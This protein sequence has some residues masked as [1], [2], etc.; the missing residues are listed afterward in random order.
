[1]TQE[2]ERELELLRK[3]EKIAAATERMLQPRYSYH[4]ELDE[5]DI[6]RMGPE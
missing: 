5:K 1:M 6:K 2:E 3:L 4:P